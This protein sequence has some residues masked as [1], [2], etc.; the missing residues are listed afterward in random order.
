M[1]SSVLHFL[2]TQLRRF[3]SARTG[4]AA[5]IFAAAAPVLIL[6][7][8]EVFSFMRAMQYRSEIQS[9]VDA[10][11]L[12][13]V[14]AVANGTRPEDGA[15]NIRRY[16]EASLP[17]GWQDY[18]SYQVGGPS[19]Q[20]DTVLASVSFAGALPTL[21]SG[22]LPGTTLPINVRSQAALEA[23]KIAATS[24]VASAINGNFYQTEAF[25]NAQEASGCKST[26]SGVSCSYSGN[27]EVWGD[28]HVKMTDGTDYFVS[29]DHPL[30][31]WYNLFSDAGLQINVQCNSIPHNDTPFYVQSFEIV[32]GGHTVYLTAPRAT[33]YADGSWSVDPK[34]AWKG[35]VTIDGVLIPAVDGVRSFLD[36]AVVTN[37]TD[38]EGACVYCLNNF[39]YVSNAHTQMA[40]TF[41]TWAEG[42][43]WLS[44]KNGGARGVPGGM[45]GIAFAGLHVANDNDF[46]MSQADSVSYPYYWTWP[47]SDAP[48]VNFSSNAHLTQ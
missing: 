27:V 33:F 14:K 46:Q 41:D 34:T 37:I 32:T 42:E 38:A 6:G 5:V 7:A 20:N 29:C 30:G 25:V 22:L 40:I 31:G 3:R 19:G 15:E 35:E 13:G 17:D 4:A 12:A 44:L 10:S 9:V 47:T 21:F 48:A 1:P 11:V 28:P 8:A 43:L 2:D 23:P 18:G 36:G 24:S 39:V 45:L 26:G 16:L